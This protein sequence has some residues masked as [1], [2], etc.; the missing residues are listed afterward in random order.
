ML[1]K[2]GDA[3]KGEQMELIESNLSKTQ[4]A[5]LREHFEAQA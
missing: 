5:K 2:V 1:E 3:F 4:E